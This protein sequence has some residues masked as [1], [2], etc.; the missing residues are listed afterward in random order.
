MHADRGVSLRSHL[1]NWRDSL[2]ASGCT[3][4]ILGLALIALFWGAVEFDLWRERLRAETVALRGT[5]NL[6]R[7][8]ASQILGSIK[9]GDRMLQSLQAAAANQTLSSEFQH[10]AGHITEFGS[11]VVQLDMTDANSDLVA[12]ST[13]ALAAT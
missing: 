8:F 2:R 3:A 11:I 13:G 9:T 5:S 1:S 4:I 6:A 12:L 7:V 10:W